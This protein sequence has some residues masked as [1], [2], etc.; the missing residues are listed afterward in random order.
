MSE[1]PPPDSGDAAPRGDFEFIS[2]LCSVVAEQAELQPILDW[3]VHKTTRLLGT[4][5][6]SIKLISASSELAHTIMFDNR[7]AGLEAGTSTWSPIVKTMVMGFLMSQPGE[8]ATPDLLADARF[9]ALKSQQTPIRALLALPLK[10]DGRVTGMISVSNASPGRV[11]SR[12]D[13]RMLGII[14]SHSA[15]VVEKARLRVEAEEKRR[16]ELE[17]DAM[18]KEL[19]LARDIQMRLVPAAPLVL[20][21]WQVEGRLIPARQVGGDFYDYFALDDARAVIIVADVAGKG[22]PAALLV[23]TVQSAVRA[24]ADGHVRPHALMDQVNRAVVR[25][26]AAGKFVTVF[27]AELDHARGVLTYVNGGHNHPRLRRA[28]G[29]IESLGT[30]GLPLGLFEGMPYEQA[31]VGF[32]PGDSLLIYSDGISEAMDSFMQE[33]EEDRLEAL[34]RECGAGSPAASITRIMDDVIAFRG[35]AAQSDD[36]TTVVIAPL[37]APGS[38]A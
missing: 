8:L 13:V 21:R 3:I 2:E 26:A 6:C 29:D 5:E 1:T 18:E 20:G 12:Q 30:G 4:E 17:R 15:S 23:S 9:P 11:W 32:G 7:R 14:A 28:N 31:E 27:Y 25:S 33:Y 10:V 35:S 34:W 16:L 24:F 37:T 22:V 19:R 38:G 36:M